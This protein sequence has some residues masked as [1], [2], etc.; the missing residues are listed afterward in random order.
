MFFYSFFCF[1]ELSVLDYVLSYFAQWFLCKVTC[2]FGLGC[3]YVILYNP[4]QPNPNEDKGGVTTQPKRMRGLEKTKILIFFVLCV[5][6]WWLWSWSLRALFV[7]V[8]RC[9]TIIYIFFVFCVFFVFFCFV[10]FC[11]FLFFLFF[12][13]FFGVF[14]ILFLIFVLPVL[15]WCFW[16]FLV[17]FWYF[18][19]ILTWFI[20]FFDYNGV[21]IK[22]AKTFASDCVPY[23][24]RCIE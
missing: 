6:I 3:V 15:D 18:F 5:I 1:F 7:F 19:L 23:D 9:K 11:F 4:I 21:T 13:V 20:S 22:R 14:L 10:F 16:C 2:G 8:L 17:V 12:L 24:K